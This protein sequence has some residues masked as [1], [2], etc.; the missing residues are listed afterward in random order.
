MNIKPNKVI[1]SAER[2]ELTA[3]ENANRIE[4]AIDMLRR[5]GFYP[6]VGQGVYRYDNGERCSETSLLL[7]SDNIQGHQDQVNVA[8]SVA[9]MFNQESILIVDSEDNAQLQYLDGRQ[10]N[11]GRLTE[12]SE[13]E[14]LSGGTG[15]SI[16]G[17]RYWICKR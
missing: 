16:F 6:M 4:K 17:G 14:A 2:S 1:F 7:S 12:V 13:A 15:Y 11:L 9:L 10:V 8:M 3:S 5:D